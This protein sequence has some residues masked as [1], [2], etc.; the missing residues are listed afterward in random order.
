[1]PASNHEMNSKRGPKQAEMLK[2][3]DAARG[4][5][6]YR[7]ARHEGRFCDTERRRCIPLP[8]IKVTTAGVADSSPL[9]CRGCV[10]CQE[11]R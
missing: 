5:R 9:W 4:D 6:T 3:S 2:R 1:M 10:A 7:D 8:T 11:L